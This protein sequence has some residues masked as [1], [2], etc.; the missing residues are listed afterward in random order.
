MSA[1]GL[2][3]L[4]AFAETVRRGSFAAA[5]REL[6]LTPSAVAKS[7]ARL[8]DDL[9]LRLLHRTTRELG[10]TSDGR[11]LF[12]RCRRIVDEIDALQGDAEGARGEPAG[13]LRVS[14]PITFG[15]RV[16][17]PILARLLARH[18]RLA[19]DLSLSDRFVDLAREGFDAAVRVGRL[20]DATLVAHAFAQQRM[21]VCASP[22]YLEA[23]GRIAAPADLPAHRC[24]V[25]RLPTSGRV[26]PWQFVVNG[27]PLAV[28]PGSA[29]AINDGEAMVVA[30]LAGAGMVQVPDNMADDA[31]RAGTLVE[32]LK[33]FRPPAQPISL[34]YPTGRQTTPRLRALTEA[35]TGRRSLGRARA[36]VGRSSARR[37]AAQG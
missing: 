15:K 18:P 12:Q 20:D 33:A 13:T 1:I 3:G 25:F 36:A 11:D 6:G 4:I 17:V 30:A 16:L 14:A 26:L 22:A 35:L 24:V 19:L 21:V 28:A 23:H 5:A 29:I 9:G 37:G 32:V 8:E 10:L 31:L 34:V 2:Q 7:V 27:Q